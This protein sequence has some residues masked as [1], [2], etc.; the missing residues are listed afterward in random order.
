MAHSEICCGYYE[1][2]VYL[3]ENGAENAPLLEVGNADINVSQELIEIEQ[4]SRQRR[5]GTNCK[6]AYTDSVNINLV[7]HCINEQ[8][9]AIAFMGNAEELTGTVEDE[10][11]P[12]NA[13]H[14][15]IDFD[16]IP[17]QSQTIEVTD[18]D[19]TTYVEG[20]DYILTAAGIK[21]IE[22]SAIPVDGSDVVVNYSYGTNRRVNMNTVA[23][24]E[25]KLV[26]D[27][28]NIGEDQRRAVVFKAWKVK[29]NPT[30]EFIILSDAEEFSSLEIAGEVLRDGSRVSGSEY[31]Q[32][33]FGD[34]A[35]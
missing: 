27:G 28:W 9:L 13:I 26:F 1:G 5:G 32:F 21:I 30:E 23:Q 3:Q 20:E 19:T 33:E 34:I 15:L 18:G 17:D 24:K 14:E 11:H 25:Y 8:N 31:M 10:A 7:L 22:G 6:V 2:T 29:F 4:P 35:S 12:V 16:F